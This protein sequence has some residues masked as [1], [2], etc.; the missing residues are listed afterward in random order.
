MAEILVDAS[1][2]QVS[3]GA[4]YLFD[5]DTGFQWSD[6]TWHNIPESQ[7]GTGSGPLTSFAK[8]FGGVV[9]DQLA[10]PAKLVDDFF[11]TA[12]G[13]TTTPFV[14]P[15]TPSPYAREL[16]TERAR[17]QAIAG[18]AAS[19]VEMQAREEAEGSARMMQGLARGMPTQYGATRG[20]MGRGAV[21]ALTGRQEQ[22][23]GVLQA[24]QQ[25]AARQQGLALTDAQDAQGRQEAQDQRSALLAQRIAERKQLEMRRDQKQAAISTTVEAGASLASPTPDTS[26]KRV[27]KN[28]KPG[29][30]DVE[31]MLNAISAKSYEMKSG[32]GPTVGVIAQDLQKG[33]PMGKEM[34]GDDNGTLTVSAGPSPVLAALAYLNDKIDRMT[35][36]RSA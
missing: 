33:G 23:M 36:K 6:G 34:V 31:K 15:D 30:S 16:A 19:P 9:V 7:G 21:A 29:D 2:A 28:I 26:D 10:T 12:P 13:A 8:D 18:G 3:G 27:K 35:E 11:G 17:L 32:G 20:R 5:T 25:A 22:D 1:G 14:Y 4:G 24:Q